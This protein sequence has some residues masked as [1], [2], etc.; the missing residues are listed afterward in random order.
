MADIKEVSKQ[1]I[2]TIDK[3]SIAQEKIKDVG[4]KTKESIKETTETNDHSP[5]EY[6]TNKTEVTVS[7]GVSFAGY[8]FNK[9][10]RKSYENTKQDIKTVKESLQV[11]KGSRAAIETKTDTIIEV[12]ENLS[13]NDIKTVGKKAVKTSNRADGKVIDKT[14]KTVE[15]GKKAAQVAT[16]NNAIK[17][18]AVK[19]SI[20]GAKKAEAIAKET[21]KET[22]KFAKKGFEVFVKVMKETIQALKSTI[23]AIIAGGW[24][25]VIII[26]LICIIGAVAGSVY[27][28]FFSSENTGT[29]M[30]VRTV[31]Q[32][33][34][35]EFDNTIDNIK[36]SYTYDE[37]E[38]NGTKSNWKDVLAIFSV[39]TTTDTTNPQEV[40][41]MDETK[42]SLLSTIFWDMNTLTPKV[43]TRT[44]TKE[45]ETTDE[46]GN[47]VTTIQ[48]VTITALC[49]TIESKTAND[50][51]TTYSF[52]DTQKEYLAELLDDSNN[53]LWN[54]LIYN[55]GISGNIDISNINFDNET[56]ND[57]QKKIVAV[58]V[59]SADYGISARSGYCQAWVSDVYQSVT[60]SRG[61]AHCALCAA[62]SWSV[63]SDWSAIQVGATVYGYASNPY[64]HV[65]IYI[66]NG[67]V[68]HNLSGTI[69]TQSLESWVKQYKGF[70]WGWENGK[71]LSGDT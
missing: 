36:S 18:E 22:T 45:V 37:V 66:G 39:R 56:V 69:T 9:I 54:S 55:V 41:I 24:L 40:M 65:G 14:V 61:S 63:S 7:N 12:T 49:I 27:G 53:S 64:G 30:T 62:D 29:G 52:T 8:S 20:N 59:N 16:Q 44:E 2:K 28:I 21:A 11:K 6:A 70:S 51:A 47:T 43:E 35:D 17:Q 23:S 32:E 10:G 5:N 46:E 15:N 3:V 60:G 42:K 71:N 4:I 34:N 1:T 19:Q 31:V 67:M 57:K 50:M 13:A 58:A 33:I 68:I 25:S 38:I 48:D 26:I